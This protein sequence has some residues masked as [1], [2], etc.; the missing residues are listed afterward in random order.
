MIR[1]GRVVSTIHAGLV[2]R[3]I[4]GGHDRDSRTI[5]G[6]VDDVLL[7][8]EFLSIDRHL[9]FHCSIVIV[10]EV[11]VG[12]L[13]EVLEHVLKHLLE[14][15]VDIVETMVM[16]QMRN[17]SIEE[18]TV[19]HWI[20]VHFEKVLA[21]FLVLLDLILEILHSF[22]R[23]G[24][25]LGL[26]HNGALLRRC[27]FAFDISL[28]ADVDSVTI[29][30]TGKDQSRE[31]DSEFGVHSLRGV[32]GAMNKLKLN[33]IALVGV[34]LIRERVVRRMLYVWV[35]WLSIVQVLARL[36]TGFKSW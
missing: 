29:D 5:G 26:H 2:L 3:L 33:A 14:H 17:S 18:E 34:L 4:D 30:Q 9:L 6:L 28:V 36:M 11:V 8:D 1:G 7:L 21:T 20:V 19:V 16:E 35:D 25:V 10:R 27:S 15:V 32:F 13:R 22:K 12:H 31:E 23:V 24:L